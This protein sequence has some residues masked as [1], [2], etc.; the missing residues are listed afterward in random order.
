[1]HL[2]NEAQVAK[3][4]LYDS[5]YRKLSLPLQARIIGQTHSFGRNFNKLC[6]VVSEIDTNLK[7]FNARRINSTASSL[8]PRIGSRQFARNTQ[9][10]STQIKNTNPFLPL[11]TVA[12]KAK[13]ISQE[14]TREL[15]CQP[16]IT[17]Y[18]CQSTS[19]YSQDCPKP[20]Q[21]ADIKEIAEKEYDSDSDLG[22]E[23]A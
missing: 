13:E 10:P 12:D 14:T 5:L 8:T 23:E 17:C 21:S 19:Y 1:M 15:T 7:R 20:K 18:N 22:K 9:T 11:Q 4:E 3:S 16:V 6:E 2:A